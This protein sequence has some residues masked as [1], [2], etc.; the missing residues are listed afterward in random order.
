MINFEKGKIYSFVGPSGG[1]KSYS[2]NKMREESEY[3][4]VPF[5]ETDFSDGIREILSVLIS[6]KKTNVD[7]NSI[8]YA[9][10]KKMNQSILSPNGDAFRIDGRTML[11]N[12]GEFLKD[13]IHNEIWANLALNDIMNKYLKM[14]VV[15][16]TA[17]NIVFGSLRF[18]S[19]LK[20]IIKCAELTHKEVEIRF[21]NYNN[22]KPKKGYIHP[23]EEMAQRLL[24]YGAEHNDIVNEYFTVS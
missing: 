14:N 19:E 22:E 16:R 23:S 4:G 5:I 1:G 12:L 24:V 7:V 21:C 20:A 2:A 17:C 18:E 8:E 3:Y 11:K 10:W 9:E 15:D 6:G 13:K